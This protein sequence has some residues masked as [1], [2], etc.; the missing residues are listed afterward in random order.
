M[1]EMLDIEGIAPYE[2]LAQF[3]DLHLNIPVPVQQGVRLPPAM[4][5]LVRL[6]PHEQPVLAPYYAH[7][8]TGRVDQK[9]LHL[10]NLHFLLLVFLAL[11]GYG[12]A[13]YE[14]Q[15]SRPKSN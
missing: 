8:T 9:G 2:I 14:T 12:E 3:V 11:D 13:I 10:R 5:T 4:N 7:T 1:G 15:V 6:H